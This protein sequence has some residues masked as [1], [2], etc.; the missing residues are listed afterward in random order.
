MISLQVYEGPLRLGDLNQEFEKW[1]LV[2][3]PDFE[4]IPD[5]M[6]IF[7]LE[8]GLYAVFQYRGLNTDNRIFR[9]I[10]NKWLPQSGFELDERPHFEVLGEKYKNGSPDSEEEIWIPVRTKK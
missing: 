5:G 1:A 4:H 10:F 3:V 8:S 2:E 6:N 7:N 9:Y